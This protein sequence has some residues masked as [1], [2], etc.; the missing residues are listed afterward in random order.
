MC[1]FTNVGLY[2]TLMKLVNEKEPLNVYSKEITFDFVKLRKVFGVHKM[3][4][5]LFDLAY[6]MLYIFT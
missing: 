4:L 2:A 1:H 5:Y 6:Y 3:I